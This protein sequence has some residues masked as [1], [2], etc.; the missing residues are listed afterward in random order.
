MLL[1]Y[2]RTTGR[3]ARDRKKKKRSKSVTGDVLSV[4]S[5]QVVFLLSPYYSPPTPRHPVL[6]L[7]QSSLPATDESDDGFPMESLHR[8]AKCAVP[9]GLKNS[10]ADCRHVVNRVLDAVGGDEKGELET[11][12]EPVLH[13]WRE[14]PPSPR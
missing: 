13:V 11:P 7:L 4:N 12:G 5:I 14:S 9:V 10:C 8:A 2:A 1:R 3:A 6:F